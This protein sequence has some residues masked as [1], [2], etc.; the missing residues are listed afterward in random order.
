MNGIFIVTLFLIYS[1]TYVFCFAIFR[2]GNFSQQ[3]T[4]EAIVQ[5]IHS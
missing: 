1:D 4:Q 2:K 3:V 5:R